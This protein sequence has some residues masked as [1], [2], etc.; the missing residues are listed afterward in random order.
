MAVVNAAVLDGKNNHL[1]GVKGWLLF[2][3][4][5]LMIR[6]LLY[7]NRS[8]RYFAQGN[9]NVGLIAMGFAVLM[10]WT[11][12]EIYQRRRQAVTLAFLGMVG[13]FAIY[14][15]TGSR[16][17]GY[18]IAYIG[19]WIAYLTRSKRVKATLIK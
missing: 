10:F 3:V 9:P 18:S 12:V 11:V 13:P 1:V 15:F 4:L 2:F 5:S 8:V 14:V 6:G 7:M 17:I 16:A 19:I